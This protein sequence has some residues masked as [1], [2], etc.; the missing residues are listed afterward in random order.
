MMAGEPITYFV[1]ISTYSFSGVEHHIRKLSGYDA[2]LE[3]ISP[4]EGVLSRNFLDNT[5]C[6]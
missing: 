3:R 4:L 5:G 2:K 1:P 6:N